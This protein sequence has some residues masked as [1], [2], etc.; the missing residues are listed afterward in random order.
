MQKNA[1]TLDT[2]V[3]AIRLAFGLANTGK[4][5]IKHESTGSA[6]C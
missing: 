3:E 5:T 2:L 4:T 6:Y 1:P